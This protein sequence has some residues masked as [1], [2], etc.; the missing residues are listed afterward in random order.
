MNLNTPEIVVLALQ[1]TISGDLLLHR[2]SI[3]KQ[4][5]DYGMWSNPKEIS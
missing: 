3:F 2:E 4:V 1:H 5:S